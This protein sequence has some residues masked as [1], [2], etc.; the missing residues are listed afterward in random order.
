M[1][2]EELSKHLRNLADACCRSKHPDYHDSLIC[3]GPG[4]EKG[5]GPPCDECLAEVTRDYELKRGKAHG[6]ELS[7]EEAERVKQQLGIISGSPPEG[8]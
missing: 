2:P 8:R 4:S 3:V 7:P 6:Q 5:F 1:T